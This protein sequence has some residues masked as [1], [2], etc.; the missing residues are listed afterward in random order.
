M[1]VFAS[2]KQVIASSGLLVGFGVIVRYFERDTIRSEVCM[3]YHV[4]DFWTEPSKVTHPDAM[5]WYL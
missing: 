5:V 3:V 4:A 2:E 1:D